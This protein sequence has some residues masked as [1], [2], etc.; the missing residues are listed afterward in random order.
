[1]SLSRMKMSSIIQCL[2]YVFAALAAVY[3][4]PRR[5]QG[6]RQHAA[7]VDCHFNCDHTNEKRQWNT[8]RV[9][10]RPK[11]M[12][13]KLCA[14]EQRYNKDPYHSRRHE[15]PIHWPKHSHT[16]SPYQLHNSCINGQL[17]YTKMR[18]VINFFAATTHNKKT[19]SGSTTFVVNN[20][21]VI[22]LPILCVS[23]SK[24]SPVFC[25]C[26]LMV[27]PIFDRVLIRYRLSH[28]IWISDNTHKFGDQ[29]PPNVCVCSNR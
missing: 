24:C 9:L 7:N 15:R 23:Q 22:F 16:I 26:N 21:S 29:H 12:C 6:T 3:L 1:M 11:R 13:F 8:F 20:T 10:R 28:A 14:F 2:R 4:W 5:M 27:P 19:L 25:D 17:T 18:H